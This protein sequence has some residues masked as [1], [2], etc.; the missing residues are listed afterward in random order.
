MTATS[1]LWAFSHLSMLSCAQRMVMEPV[2]PYL[3]PFQSAQHAGFMYA[4]TTEW[5]ISM[6]WGMSFGWP[7]RGAQKAIVTVME[8]PKVAKVPG[9]P[10]KRARTF[11]IG[12]TQ[13]G[14][15]SARTA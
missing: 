7:R 3:S 9:V 10:V 1:G 15:S 11:F 6:F 8:S 14:V 4:L 2:L 13:L 5:A 12:A